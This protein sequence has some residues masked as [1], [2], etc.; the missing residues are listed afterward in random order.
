MSWV[1]KIKESKSGMNDVPLI[2]FIRTLGG[3]TNEINPILY[4]LIKVECSKPLMMFRGIENAFLR[5]PNLYYITG[6]MNEAKKEMPFVDINLGDDV[7]FRPKRILLDSRASYTYADLRVRSGDDN[8]DN[9]YMSHASVLNLK[10][11]SSKDF[12]LKFPK[13]QFPSFELFPR[14]N[15]NDDYAAP[16]SSL[17][18]ELNK[19]DKNTDSF[20]ITTLEIT[21]TFDPIK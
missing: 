14:E 15:N 6:I 9:D 16:L 3:S 5:D 4:N 19:N 10:T 8:L 20:R 21:G 1:K 2:E 18:L 11:S 17:R 7:L 13:P 12:L